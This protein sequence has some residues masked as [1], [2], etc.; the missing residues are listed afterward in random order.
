MSIADQIAGYVSETGY[1]D[2]DPVAIERTKD[3]CLSSIGSAV[4]G[5]RMA[6]PAILAD[7]VRSM[8]GPGPAGVTGFGFSTSAELAA[9]VNCNLTHFTELE[10]VALPEE[11]HTCCPFPALVPPRQALGNRGRG[12]NTRK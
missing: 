10:D 9:L 8:N 7:Y 2:F 1:A 12:G 11:P 4:L 6:V 3:L 5:A